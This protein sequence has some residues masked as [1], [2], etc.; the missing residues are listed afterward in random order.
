MRA[1]R[2]EEVREFLK[3]RR[4]MIKPEEVGFTGGGRR[5]VPGLRRQE[6]ARLAGISTEY[7]ARIERGYIDTVSDAVVESVASALRLD[8]SDRARLIRLAR[9]EAKE[10]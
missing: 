3:A 9:T 2:R 8:E 1:G 7:Y 5:Q 6:V 10:P 4:A